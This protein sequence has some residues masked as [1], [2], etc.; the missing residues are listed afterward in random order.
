M[1]E[2]LLKF[3]MGIELNEKI[4]LTDS[5]AGLQLTDLN[6]M[7]NTELDVDNN[8]DYKLLDTQVK[9]NKLNL[10]LK[11]SEAL[12]V[13]AGF[14][15]YEKNFNLQGFTFNP[16]SII[17]LSVSLPI[18]SSGQRIARIKQAK[19][20]FQ[21]SLNSK[22][23]GGQGILIDFSQSK[24]D[25][26]NALDK[27]NLE[28]ENMSLADKIYKRTI[29][30]FKNGN[31]SSIDLTQVQNQYI[32][33]ESNYYRALIDLISAKSKLERLLSSN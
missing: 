32:T 14:Y 5:L 8:I 15:N 25:Y 23:Q 10:K 3:Q 1:A 26:L 9:L 17:G 31:S 13:V 29:I 19:I 28:K 16:P 20:E 2:R 22:E 27:C 33:S 7:I 18:F 24:S 11:R 21:K 6:S 4:E 12:P 30:K